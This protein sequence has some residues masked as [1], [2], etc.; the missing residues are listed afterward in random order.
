MRYTVINLPDAEDE[1]ARLW[2]AASD[3]DAVSRASNEI[4]AILR[5]FPLSRGYAHG[6]SRILTIKPLTVVYTVSPEDCQV[7]ILQYLYQ[8]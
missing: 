7:T 5:V 3:R 1:L 6:N 8:E 2:M 4:D